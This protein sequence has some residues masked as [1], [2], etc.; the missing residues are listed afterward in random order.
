MNRKLLFLYAVALAAAAAWAAWFLLSQREPAYN[1]KSLSAWIDQRYRYLPNARDLPDLAKAEE[2]QDAIR[3]IG[4]NALP[5]LLAMVRTRD[6]AI[7]KRLLAFNQRQNILRVPLKP[8]SYYHSR[9][10]YGFGAL[11]SAARP[12]VPALIELLQ[13]PDKEVRASAASCLA[14]LGPNAREAVPALMQT[15]NAE[16]NGWGPVLIDSMMALGAIHSDPEKVIPLLLEYVDGPRKQW[17]YAVPAMEALTRY[18]EQATSA[19]P[20]ILP[21]LN[22]PDES[23][24]SAA[25]AALCAIDPQGTDRARRAALAK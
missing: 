7:K 13:D 6:S 14:L 18:R 12:A 9:A 2:A 8:A 24:R 3:Q 23:H 1:G 11:R 22:D 15:L 4:T 21:Y 19:V 10:T 20:A 25:D 5:S 16:G 17:N